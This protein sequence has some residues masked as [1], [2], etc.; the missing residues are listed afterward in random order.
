MRFLV[1]LKSRNSSPGASSLVGT[2]LLLPRAMAEFT[3]YRTG[4]Y[5]GEPSSSTSA[6]RPL[7]EQDELA[8]GQGEGAMIK[9]VKETKG[10]ASEF[11]KKLYRY[12][13]PF[14]AGPRDGWRVDTVHETTGTGGERVR[15]FPQ[16]AKPIPACYRPAQLARPVVSLSP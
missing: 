8:A 15:S 16:P 2:D 9:P 7:L 13:N 3:S 4:V 5:M 12:V 1:E 10:G 6:H 14:R 11:V